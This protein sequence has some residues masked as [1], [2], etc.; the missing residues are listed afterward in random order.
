MTKYQRG[1]EFIALNDD[2]GS[3]HAENT[4]V[5]EEMVSVVLMSEIFG[6]SVSEIAQDVVKFRKQ[7]NKRLANPREEFE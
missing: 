1:I 6:K 2:N 4:I 3:Q 5:V 7:W